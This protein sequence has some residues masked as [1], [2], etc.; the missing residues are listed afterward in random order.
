MTE[1]EVVAAARQLATSE[2]RDLSRYQEPS[3][4]LTDGRWGVLFQG[5]SLAPGNHF[6]V[7][8]DDQTGESRMV[9]GR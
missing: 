5:K 6:L 9:G 3:A 4:K 1:D 8:I 2:G 7:T